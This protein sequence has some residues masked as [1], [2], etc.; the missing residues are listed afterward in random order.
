MS[1]RSPAPVTVPAN[2]DTLTPYDRSHFVTYL[3]LL[4][5]AAM[6]ADW[7]E[8]ARTVLSLDPHIDPDAARRSYDAH[9]ARARWMTQTGYRQLLK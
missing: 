7:K 4:D 3:K 2:G 9:L 1:D 6:G 5:A 8:T